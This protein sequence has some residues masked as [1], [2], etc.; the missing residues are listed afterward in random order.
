[1]DE[2]VFSNLKREGNKIDK[3]YSGNKQLLMKSVLAPPIKG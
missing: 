3:T 1:V 2:N